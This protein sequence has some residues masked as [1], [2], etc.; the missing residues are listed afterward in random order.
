M[1]NKHQFRVVMHPADYERSLAFYRDEL[2]F[3]VRSS[4]DRGPADRG[5][6]LE[7]GAG[8]VELLDRGQP[9]PPQGVSLYWQVDD[10]DAIHAALRARGG[11]LDPP[12]DR[13]W[14]HRAIGLRD[15]DGLPLGMFHEI[16]G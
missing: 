6:V 7:V 2:G 13:P 3:P 10:V 5:C 1:S 14:G 9:R 15:P 12:V 16:E 11:A 4:W 8:H